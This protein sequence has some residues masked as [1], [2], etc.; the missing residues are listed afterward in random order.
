MAPSAYIEPGEHTGK[1]RIGELIGQ[2][3]GEAYLNGLLS[4]PNT[5]YDSAMPIRGILAADAVKPG[6]GLSIL[7]GLQR[8]QYGAPLC[9]LGSN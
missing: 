7:K 6:S 8:A 9:D 3:F 2:V 4:D 1:F 5:T